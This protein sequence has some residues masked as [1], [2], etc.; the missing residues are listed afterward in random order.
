MQTMDG[1]GSW[2][3]QSVCHVLP[4]YTILVLQHPVEEGR[5]ML[6]KAVTIGGGQGGGPNPRD[7]YVHNP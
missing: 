1:Q 4:V 6:R 5:N 2:V 3:E 7:N